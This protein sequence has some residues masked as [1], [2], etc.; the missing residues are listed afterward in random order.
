VV[1]AQATIITSRSNIKRPSMTANPSNTDG[2]PKAQKTNQPIVTKEVDNITQARPT[3][4][5][6]NIKRS[7]KGVAVGDVNGDGISA[8]RSSTIFD[9][10]GRNKSGLPASR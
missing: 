3:T 6:S 8:S 2:K 1:L 10:W 4:S 7:G 5:R 9:R